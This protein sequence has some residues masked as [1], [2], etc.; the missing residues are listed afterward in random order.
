[1]K[2]RVTVRIETETEKYEFSI[3]RYDEEAEDGEHE[4]IQSD[5]DAARL[6]TELQVD[7]VLIGLIRSNIAELQDCVMT[8]VRTIWARQDELERRLD[9]LTR[10]AAS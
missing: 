8:D 6:A 10:Y 5:E 7:P 1:M 3:W 9:A 4:E 2:T